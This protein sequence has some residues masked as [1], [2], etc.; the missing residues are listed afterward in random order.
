MPRLIQ[1]T[2]ETRIVAPVRRGMPRRHMWGNWPPIVNCS[3]FILY[4]VFDNH[5]ATGHALSLHGYGNKSKMKFGENAEQT[6]ERRGWPQGGAGF[7]ELSPFKRKD[8]PLFIGL[9][10]LSVF[11]GI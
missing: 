5:T 8:F 11:A 3:L 2:Q 7:F 4:L 9:E 1:P 10:A 6:D